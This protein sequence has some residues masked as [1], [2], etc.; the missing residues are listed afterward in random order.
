MPAVEVD[1]NAAEPSSHRRYFIEAAQH[2]MPTGA[3]WSLNDDVTFSGLHLGNMH[4]WQPEDEVDNFST[5]RKKVLYMQQDTW[6]LFGVGC[7][8]GFSV[9]TPFLPSFRLIYS[10]A[11]FRIH[12]KTHTF[13]PISISLLTLFLNIMAVMT[14]IFLPVFFRFSNATLGGHKT[15]LNITFPRVWK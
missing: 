2:H 9:A 8:C 11:Q 6:V 4:F 3:Q 12:L 5:R 14:I 10:H 1:R 15:E 7:G 13:Y